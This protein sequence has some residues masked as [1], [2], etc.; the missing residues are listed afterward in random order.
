M[1]RGE[2]AGGR[3]SEGKEP[4]VLRYPLPYPQEPPPLPLVPHQPAELR[5]GNP[6][7]EQETR[8]TVGTSFLLD[9]VRFTSFPNEMD[10]TCVPF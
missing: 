8:G 1:H 3:R 6:Y 4:M 10:I 5:F 7:S 9:I 2:A